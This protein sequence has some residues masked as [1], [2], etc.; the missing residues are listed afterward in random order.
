M[1]L[2][3][4]VWKELPLLRTEAKSQA[5]TTKKYMERT[6]AITNTRCYGQEINPWPKLKEMYGNNSGYYEHLAL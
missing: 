3:R 4:N 6:P 2:R 1:K 5:E